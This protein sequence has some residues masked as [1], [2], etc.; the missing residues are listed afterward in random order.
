MIKWE[1]ENRKI[2]DQNFRKKSKN[3]NNIEANTKR[4]LSEE[5]ETKFRSEG[6]VYRKKD[7]CESLKMR[8]R[9]W[10]G[11]TRDANFEDNLLK[12]RHISE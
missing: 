6:F 3:N 9:V 12:N 10:G 1:K 5:I 7:C 2:K 4:E 11:C 8:C